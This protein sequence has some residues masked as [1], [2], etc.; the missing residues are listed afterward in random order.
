MVEQ[1]HRFI[2]CRIRLMLGVPIFHSAAAT[3]DGIEV[4]QMIRKGQLGST[5]SGFHQFAELAG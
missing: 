5:E 3:L 1:D 4:A 2:K